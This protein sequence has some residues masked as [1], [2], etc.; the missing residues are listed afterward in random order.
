MTSSECPFCEI[1]SSSVPFPPSSPQTIPNGREGNSQGTPDSPTAFT[2]LSTKHV[3]A[4]LD[5]MPLT[6][7]HVLFTP[8][9]HYQNMREVGIHDA[10][11]LGQ[12]L[13]VLSR[14]IV[15][16]VLGEGKDSR[17]D[18]QGNWNI[19]QN[20]GIRASQ[21]VPHVHFHI[22]PRPA[23]GA[24]APAGGGWVMFG[25]G[26]RDE[27]MDDDAEELVVLL[28]TELA[29]EVKRVKEE[30]GIDLDDC[31]CGVEDGHIPRST[32]L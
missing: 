24:D 15:R 10:R 30:E 3:L 21:T 6:R 29:R 18:D 26:Q 11:Q 13:P 2:I 4:F 32:K 16:T 19:I 17:G 25:R 7:G 22:I 23:T 31:D 28:R 9:R 14:V 1:A 8:R 20:N 12:W 5:I 27:L